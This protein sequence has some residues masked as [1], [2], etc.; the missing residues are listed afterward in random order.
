MAQEKGTAEN[1]CAESGATAHN[2]DGSILS[3]TRNLLLFG[4][5]SEKICFCHL[6]HWRDPQE[7][8]PI[9]GSN[10]HS[11]GAKKGRMLEASESDDEYLF[12]PSYHQA[13]GQIGA[14]VGSDQS[15]LAKKKEQLNGVVSLGPH[16]P[17]PISKARVDEQST[18]REST[19]KA[20]LRLSFP[21]RSSER[22]REYR[23]WKR[24][25]VGKRF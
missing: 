24:S 9:P 3:L 17:L 21:R 20:G 16:I 23:N 14:A 8:I 15:E 7:L 11:G 12:Y 4:G 1:I 25:Q 10:Q 6:S 19:R 22:I 18:A 13:I 2:C 5:H